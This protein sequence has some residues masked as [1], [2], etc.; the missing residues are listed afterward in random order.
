[1]P[2]LPLR[3]RK[4]MGKGR[5]APGGGGSGRAAAREVSAEGRAGCTLPV[6]AQQWEVYL[7]WAWVTTCRLAERCLLFVGAAHAGE[8]GVAP[9]AVGGMQWVIPGMRYRVQSQ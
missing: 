1:M 7:C 6:G 5:L 2:L 9:C 3:M 4:R 8:R